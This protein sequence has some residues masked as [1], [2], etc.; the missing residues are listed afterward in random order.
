MT[1]T[2]PGY[3]LTPIVKG[4]LGES[5]KIRE[6]LDEFD[7]AMAQGVRIMALVELSDLYGAVEAVLEHQ[8]PGVTMADL[9]AMARV[10]QRAFVNGR[11]S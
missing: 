4:T 10:T 8:F 9:A 5:T 6:E 7:D 11:R 1:E 3:H 2:A